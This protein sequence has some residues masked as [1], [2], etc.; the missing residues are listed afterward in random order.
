MQEFSNE[1]RLVG[2]SAVI[3]VPPLLAL[4]RHFATPAI[5]A[6]MLLEIWLKSSPSKLL[7]IVETTVL[8]VFKYSPVSSVPS[9]TC[10]DE[11]IG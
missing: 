9:R 5:A 10:N 4:F 2:K 6:S 1:F 8:T 7:W 3:P 11:M